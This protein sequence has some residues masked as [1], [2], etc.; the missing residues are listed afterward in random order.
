MGRKSGLVYVLARCP[1]EPYGTDK[2]LLLL[3]PLDTLKYGQVTPGTVTAISGMTL[4]PPNDDCEKMRPTQK[5][6]GGRLI[7]QY[8]VLAK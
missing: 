8:L 4:D 1:L 3:A 6:A 7:T 5:R 2:A